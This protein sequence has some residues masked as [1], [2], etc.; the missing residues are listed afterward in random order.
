VSP[1]GGCQPFNFPTPSTVLCYER[2]TPLVSVCCCTARK[3]VSTGVPGHEK[4]RD[5]LRWHPFGVGGLAA[6]LS[7]ID[8]RV[9]GVVSN[10]PGFP[11]SKNIY[12][13]ST[14]RGRRKDLQP[15]G[16]A[17][18]L[19][20]DGTGLPSTRAPDSEHSAAPARHSTARAPHN[21]ALPMV[22]ADITAVVGKRSR[23]RELGLGNTCRGP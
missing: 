10:A 2:V 19:S 15:A 9:A 3:R 4:V 7:H 21:T 6:F 5:K 14:L 22:A 16:N 12:A 23:S 13:S 17:P 20:P 18:H 8:F 11:T 1:R